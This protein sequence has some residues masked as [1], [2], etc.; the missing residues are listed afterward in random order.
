MALIAS[1]MMA[2]TLGEVLLDL[3]MAI[4]LGV[5]IRH[6]MVTRTVAREPDASD[7]TVRTGRD[8]AR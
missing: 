7:T 4:V 1:L 5:G 2:L 3:P 8:A 6:A